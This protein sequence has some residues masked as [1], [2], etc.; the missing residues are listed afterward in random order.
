MVT[1]DPKVYGL[2]EPKVYGS[3][4]RHVGMPDILLHC[5]TW[6]RRLTNARV[7]KARVV[8]HAV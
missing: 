5:Q 4:H 2:C 8:K 7:V 3:K 1:I 6:R